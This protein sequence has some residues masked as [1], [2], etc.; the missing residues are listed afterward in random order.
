M[1]KLLRL[2]LLFLPVLLLSG[3]GSAYYSGSS[4]HYYGGSRHYRSSW[5]YDDYYRSRVNRYYNRNE[6]RRAVQRET[7]RRGA[8]R[9][10]AVRRGARPVQRSRPVRVR[11]R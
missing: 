10:E 11:H 9:R 5:D 4:R 3:C 1:K 6:V 7:V 8:V 2:F